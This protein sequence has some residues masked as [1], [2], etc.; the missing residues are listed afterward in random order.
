L[1]EREEGRGTL[2]RCGERSVPA[3]SDDD[4]D[5]DDEVISEIEAQ[6]ASSRI[7]QRE[8]RGTSRL[9]TPT[10]TNQDQQLSTHR[11]PKI[12]SIQTVT[13]VRNYNT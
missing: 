8:P 3:E 2:S 5:D 12:H 7:Q 6:H 1:D 11:Q 13:C 4:D 10:Q 9:V